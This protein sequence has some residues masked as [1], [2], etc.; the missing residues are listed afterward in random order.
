MT[1]GKTE[2]I[3]DLQSYLLMETPKAVLLG[4]PHTRQMLYGWLALG[5]YW[6]NEASSRHN[7]CNV[8][9]DRC[10]WTEPHLE[11]E[12]ATLPAPRAGGFG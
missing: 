10:S 8:K 12:A 4:T 7:G 11:T 1:P 3:S 6:V 2:A 5:K 9:S